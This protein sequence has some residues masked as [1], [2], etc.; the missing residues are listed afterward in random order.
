MC[1]CLDGQQVVAASGTSFECNHL[2]AH[3]THERSN[4]PVALRNIGTKRVPCDGDR[5]MLESPL[6]RRT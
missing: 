3:V 5:V 4:T 6:E 1:C 2:G